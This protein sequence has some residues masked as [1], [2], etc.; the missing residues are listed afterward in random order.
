MTIR[1][2]SCSK[3]SE[4]TNAELFRRALLNSEP[5]LDHPDISVEILTALPLQRAQIDLVMIYHDPRP[6]ELL[7]RTAN[8]TPIHS[9]VLVVE[10]KHHSSDLVRFDGVKVHVQYNGK[11][12]N[13]TDQCDRQTYALKAFQEEA[14]EGT[15]RRGSTFVQRAIWLPRVSPASLKHAPPRGSVSVHLSDLT[16]QNLV[17]QFVPN[18]DQ[19]RTLVDQDSDRHFSFKDLRNHLAYEIIPT[20]LDLR[21]MNALT[22]TRFD[23]DKTAYIRNLGNGLLIIRGRGGTGKTFALL[24]IAIHLA[25]EGKRSALLTYNHGL[26]AD[27]NRTLHF[28]AEKG[29]I[30]RKSIEVMTRYEFIKQM[31]IERLGGDAE[32]V[33]INHIND[34]AE[35]ERLRLT[36]LNDRESFLGRPIEGQ[37]PPYGRSPCC[38]F[39]IEERRCKP[40]TWRDVAKT[41]VDAPSAY[42]FVLVDEGQDWSDEQRDLLYK[43]VGS[44]KVVVA[45][46]IDQFVGADRCEWDTGKVRINRRHGLRASRR[47]KAATCQ[48]VADIA[49]ELSLNDW[50]LQ[51]DPDAHGGRLTVLLEPDPRRAMERTFDLLDAD[52]RDERELKS[53]DNLLCLPSP[54]MTTGANYQNLF[55][56]TLEARGRDSWRGFSED[57]RREFPRRSG[58]LRT[59]L[60]NSCRGMEGWTTACLALDRFYDFQL[61]NHRVDEEQLRAEMGLLAS[62]NEV[63]NMLESRARQFAANW[64]MIPLTRSIDHLII[65]LADENSMLAGVLKNVDA[66]AAGAIT[67]IR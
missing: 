49:R 40:A 38:L 5:A 56:A 57:G 46:G 12:S 39:E 58:Q 8:G 22:Q 6:V 26:I 19:I 21:R 28:L 32:R 66:R 47:T 13:A 29:E 42:D 20:R 53:V 11:W 44:E 36:A 7:L 18:R 31:F 54:L 45:D 61:R 24:Q 50:D 67:W 48:T 30:A 25:S 23:A 9:F 37:C 60:Y 63:A 55:D 2:T 17:S 65:H 59:I 16:W 41:R 62:E 3:D 51:P 14:F 64:L 34:I 35:R 15:K 43:S 27:I 52:L 1:I 4:T 10:V 33:M